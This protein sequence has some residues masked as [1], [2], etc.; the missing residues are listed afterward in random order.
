[1]CNYDLLC[2]RQFAVGQE[3]SGGKPAAGG[4]AGGGCGLYTAVKKHPNRGALVYMHKKGLKWLTVFYSKTNVSESW[5]KVVDFKKIK[6]YSRLHQEP[7]SAG[8]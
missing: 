2:G 3:N 5:K 4:G 8:N 7:A 6:C 1:M